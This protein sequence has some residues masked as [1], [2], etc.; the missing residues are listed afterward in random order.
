MQELTKREADLWLQNLKHELEKTFLNKNWDEKTAVKVEKF[1]TQAFWDELYLESDK[2]ILWYPGIILVGGNVQILKNELR[3]IWKTASFPFSRKLPYETNANKVDLG[4]INQYSVH[5][6]K[7]TTELNAH[8]NGEWSNV[9]L[10]S[11]NHTVGYILNELPYPF[12]LAL[13]RLLSLNYKI[14]CKKIVVPKMFAVHTD[15]GTLVR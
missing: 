2:Y 10:Q 9:K 14:E 7:V 12:D 4:T 13:K 11:D 3:I 1:L 6:D 5:Y 15:I 8:I